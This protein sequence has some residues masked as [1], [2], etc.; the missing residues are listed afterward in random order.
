MKRIIYCCIGALLF[1][2]CSKDPLSGKLSIP[3]NADWKSKVYL[4]QPRSLDEVCTSFG[5]VVIDSATVDEN[6][7]F[8]FKEMPEAD[9]P[10]LLEL[11][12]QKK[13]ERFLNKLEQQDL[14]AANYFPIVWQTGAIVEV[15]ADI[16]QFQQSFDIKSPSPE[17][18]AL[19]QLR[20]IRYKANEDFFSEAFSGA[21]AIIAAAEALHNFREPLI[22]FAAET[23]HLLPALVAMRWVSPQNDYERVPEFL[24]NQ[25]QKWQSK[26]ASHP[27]VVQLCEKSN[28][29]KLP[30]L[31]GEEVPDFP[32]PTLSGDTTTLYKLKGERLTLLDLWASWC[33]PCRRENRDVLVPLWDKYHKAGF[34]IVG[35]ALDASEGTWKKAITTDGADRWIH[36]SHLQGD[37]APLMEALRLQTIP[38]NLLLDINGKVLAKNLHGVA[39]MK[40]V[41]AYFRE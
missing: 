2:S 22:Q 18:A 27:F 28:L 5:G 34:Q 20:D 21:E 24:V 7:R 30:V 11:V 6:G 23:E 31:V 35:Y 39:L 32:L 40:F 33:A 16:N 8:L 3:L 15:T 29:N 36:T 4:V 37:D 38:A 19:L 12:V 41:E 10:I 17:N 25:C 13:G 26:Y 14:D 1:I 9:E